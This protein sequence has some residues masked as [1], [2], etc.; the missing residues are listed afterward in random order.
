MTLTQEQSQELNA[1]I[2]NKELDET[3]LPKKLVDLLDTMIQR[4]LL[5]KAENLNL[6]AEQ[7]AGA[8]HQSHHDGEGQWA[9]FDAIGP[10][11]SHG[12]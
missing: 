11:Q 9:V 7:S 12:P 3:K 6:R 2:K 5:N 4:D 1:K 10:I 8:E